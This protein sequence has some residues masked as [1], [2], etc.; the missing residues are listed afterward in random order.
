[1]KLNPVSSFF[2]YFHPTVFAVHAPT[3]THAAVKWTIDLVPLP[4]ASATAIHALDLHDAI[5]PSCLSASTMSPTVYAADPVPPVNVL[6]ARTAAP[7]PA[8]TNAVTCP[9]VG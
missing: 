8:P 7:V 4:N 6:S 2:V 9:A 5:K 3:T 1:M